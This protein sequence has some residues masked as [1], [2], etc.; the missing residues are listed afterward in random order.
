[1]LFLLRAEDQKRKMKKNPKPLSG[2]TFEGDLSR[3]HVAHC[4]AQSDEA[5]NDLANLRQDHAPTD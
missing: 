1:M 5:K 4:C 3:P 2:A